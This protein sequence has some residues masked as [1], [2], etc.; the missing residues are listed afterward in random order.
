[1]NHTKP[2]HSISH[3]F[4]S[5]YSK[6]HGMALFLLCNQY[7]M[8]E[9][10]IAKG[11]TMKHALRQFL[12]G[13]SATLLLAV[14]SLAHAAYTTYTN[15]SAFES[16]LASFSVDSLDGIT[17]YFH[18]SDA[19]P[20]FNISTIDYYF[21]CINQEGCGD[22]SGIGF[23]NSYVWMYGGNY[24]SPVTFTFSTARNGFGFDF[25]NP[26]CCDY[27][28]TPSIDGINNPE[29]SGFF[30]VIYDT[31][32][33][34]FVV[35]SSNSYMLVDNITY[36]SGNGNSVPEPASLVLLGL[37]LIGLGAIRR[38]QKVA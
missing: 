25:A 35:T 34:S 37:G 22:N 6:C 15:R 17:S 36:G 21:G 32:M 3:Y 9:P 14:S 18:S 13:F 12:L 27:G 10:C 7:T 8:L 24:N 4:S 2:L 11:I 29:T 20:D 31:A 23:D 1:M 33:T 16:A 5:G 26:V 38:K 19:R 28:S 30:G